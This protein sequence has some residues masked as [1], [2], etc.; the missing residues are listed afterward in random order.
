VGDCIIGDI[1][2]NL[3]RAMILIYLD[4]PKSYV[5]ASNLCDSVWIFCASGETPNLVNFPV[6]GVGNLKFY[7]NA[8]CKSLD[9]GLFLWDT[10]YSSD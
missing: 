10:E 6:R 8:D 3:G 9:N 1:N 7:Q 2:D 4:Y 5:E